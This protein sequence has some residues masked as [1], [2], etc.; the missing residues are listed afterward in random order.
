MAHPPPQ[1]GSSDRAAECTGTEK[2]TAGLL[3]HVGV[4]S[5]PHTPLVDARLIGWVCRNVNRVI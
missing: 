1:E 5:R 2:E 3:E 4:E